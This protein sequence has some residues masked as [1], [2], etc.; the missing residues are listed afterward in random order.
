M[1]TSVSEASTGMKSLVDDWSADKQT[2]DV[3]WGKLMMNATHS[4]AGDCLKKDQLL[5]MLGMRETTNAVTNYE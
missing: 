1:N 3:P 4:N 2:F 5:T